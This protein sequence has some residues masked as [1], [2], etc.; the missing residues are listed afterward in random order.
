MTPFLIL[1][2]VRGEPAFDIAIRCDDMGTESDP[3]PWWIIPTSGHRAYPYRHWQLEDLA[4]TSDINANGYNEH[5]WT[6]DKVPDDWPD[7]Y[8]PDRG[9]PAPQGELL[10]LLSGLIGHGPALPRRTLR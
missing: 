10:A 4:D 7:H 8:S 1:H 2:K 5:P 9:Q 6:H 3:G